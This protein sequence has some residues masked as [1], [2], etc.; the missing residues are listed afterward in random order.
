MP[1]RPRRPLLRAGSSRMPSS[2]APLCGNSPTTAPSSPVKCPTMSAAAS[3]V[4]A[5]PRHD[6]PPQPRLLPIEAR[7]PHRRGCPAAP[8]LLRCQ[9]RARRPRIRWPSAR[10][11]CPQ[12][13]AG[14]R[15]VVPRPW[16][17]ARDQGQASRLS[18]PQGQAR[19]SLFRVWA[20][21][22]A[23]PSQISSI[24]VGLFSHLGSRR[25]PSA[26]PDRVAGLVALTVGPTSA[27]SR[28]APLVSR[29]ALCTV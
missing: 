13:P 14:L 6:T 18:S 7:E 24:R 1:E 10:S 29:S 9:E 5:A 12:N 3:A 27:A 26:R 21:A 17:R 2:R 25:P 4:V 23:R 15:V 20:A 16:M 19:L 28:V 8:R 11:G 22:F